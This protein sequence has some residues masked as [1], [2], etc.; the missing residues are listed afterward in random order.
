MEKLAY[1]SDLKSDACNGHAGS[2]PAR[3]TKQ[4]RDPRVSS[5]I[6]EWLNAEFISRINLEVYSVDGNHLAVT[7]ELV[8]G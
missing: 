3:R 8:N 2:S 6:H 1:S 5:F 4:R 7:T